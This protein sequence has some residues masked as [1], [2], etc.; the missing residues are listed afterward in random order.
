MYWYHHQ[1]KCM[2]GRVF[3][4][5]CLLI[6][7]PRITLSTS[8]NELELLDIKNIWAAND[9]IHKRIEFTASCFNQLF[10]IT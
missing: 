5:V 10:C 4:D 2:H 8:G 9:A 6:R 3:T 1:C 7:Y